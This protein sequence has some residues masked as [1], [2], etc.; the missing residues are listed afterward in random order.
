MI[1]DY[2]T[3]ELTIKEA[4]AFYVTGYI[5]LSSLL[6]LFYHSLFLSIVAGCLIHFFKP[7]LCRMLAAKRMDRL[8]IQFKDMLYS[9]SASVASGR[10]MEDALI[11]AYDNLA[12]LYDS[13]QPIMKELYHMKISITENKESDKNL[14]TDLAYRTRNEDISNFVQVY[15]TCRSMG[16]DLESI[17]SRTAEILTDKM[18]IDKEIRTI[19]SQKKMEGRI[20]ALMPIFML[21]V[22]N[23]LSSSY[24]APLYDTIE[25]KL[26]MTGA[27]AAICCGTYLM[28]KLSDIEI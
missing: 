11:E 2:S 27:L 3:Y 8:Q 13:N 5:C 25:G 14:L 6:Y 15:V 21:L 12:L 18:N 26:I 20:I 7:E 16:G 19:T 22:L 28:E 17:I 10:Q 24:I 9:L 23:M 1:K 4:L